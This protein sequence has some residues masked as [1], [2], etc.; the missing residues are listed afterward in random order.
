M[1]S[2]RILVTNDDGIDSPGIYA[3]WKA[4]SKVGTPTVIAPCTE[5]S[6]ASHSI[7]LNKPLFI[8]YIS[9]DYG[10]EGWSVNGT[11]ADCTK[12]GINEVLKHRPDL[13][14]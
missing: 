12:I 9:R 13:I 4:M 11:P 10:F 2:P 8:N 6:A 5:Q 1:K 7:T 14:V 3:L